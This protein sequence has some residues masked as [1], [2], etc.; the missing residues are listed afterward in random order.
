MD[1]KAKIEEIVA[2]LM[3]DKSLLAKFKTDPVS[4]VKQLVGI[5]LPNDTM[6]SLVDGVKAKMAM[7]AASS[8]LGNLG[9]LFGKK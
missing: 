9:G 3:A 1:I 5:S 4:V 7:S 6:S 8:V 2:K